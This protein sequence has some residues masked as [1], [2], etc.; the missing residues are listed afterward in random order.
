M[1]SFK[2]RQRYYTSINNFLN[3]FESTELKCNIV[4]HSNNKTMIL[5]NTPVRFHENEFKNDET[6]YTF[7]VWWNEAEKQTGD[8]ICKNELPEAFDSRYITITVYRNIDRLYFSNSWRT[9]IR[10]CIIPY[11]D[12]TTEET[13]KVE[14]E[15]RKSFN[16][17]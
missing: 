15:Y 13:L 14:E 11:R 16:Y 4:V 7:S 6:Y 2:D 17:S 5:W 10:C 8:Q 1:K 3:N 12:G 9:V